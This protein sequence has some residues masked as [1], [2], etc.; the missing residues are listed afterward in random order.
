[1]RRSSDARPE[2]G[3]T[4]AEL[5]VAC[6]V[7]G[8]VMAGLLIMLQTGQQS[9]LVGAHQ[10]E[11]QQTVRVAL[12]EMIR[13]LRN[14]GYCPTCTG[15]APFTAITAQSGTGFAIQS[16]WDGS[17]TI[18]TSGT[19]TDAAGTVRGERIIYAV[20]S[21][22]LTR[23]ETG[24]DASPLT[25]ATG[26]TSLGFTYQ[27]SAGVTTATAADIR[28]IVLTLTAQPRVQPAATPQGRALVTMTDSVRLRNR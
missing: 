14:A 5:L 2:G 25:V 16:D 17:G 1:M 9:Y 27:D 6:A 28:T 22:A 10:V 19:V 23:Q 15:T 20:S 7:T 4:L 11:A 12:D 18:S 13:E 8:F 3:F 21:G 26:I 24:I